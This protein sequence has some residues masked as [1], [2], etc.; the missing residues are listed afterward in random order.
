MYHSFTVQTVNFIKIV[1]IELYSSQM[2]QQE[3]PTG[4][5]I[6]HERHPENKGACNG[7]KTNYS[8]EKNSCLNFVA[9]FERES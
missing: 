6:A 7:V 4:T 5:E 1:E 9:F 8:F 2:K 3:H